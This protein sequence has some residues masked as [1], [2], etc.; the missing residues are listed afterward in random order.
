MSFE[1]NLIFFEDNEETHI[2]T[3]DFKPVRLEFIIKELRRTCEEVER[4]KTW[5]KDEQARIYSESNKCFEY[6]EERLK[7]DS[8]RIK[9]MRECL[10]DISKLD[11]S[12]KPPDIVWLT[13]W[14]N[15]TKFKAIRA[16]EETK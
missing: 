16:L 14:R 8:D 10:E 4:L 1:P 12:D 6:T 11:T 15:N 3:K 5:I 2:R 13:N 7:K 9:I